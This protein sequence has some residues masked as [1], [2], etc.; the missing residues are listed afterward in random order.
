M[1]GLGFILMLPFFLLMIFIKPLRRYLQYVH[2]FWAV[3][4]LGFSG[5]PWRIIYQYRPQRKRQYVICSN[6]FSILDIVTMG[7]LPINAVFVGKSSLAKIPLFGYMFRK[8]HITVD[9]SSLKDR[10]RALQKA[11]QAVDEGKSL[12]MFPEGGV[13]TECPPQMIRFK[14]GPFRVAIEKQ[15]PILPITIPYNWLILPDDKS[16]LLY[17]RTLFVVVHPA[18]ET[19]GLGMDAIP[20]L[21]QQLYSTIDEELKKYNPDESRQRDPAKDCAPGTS[22]V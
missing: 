12:I 16:Y 3:F 1:F 21:Q 15:I 13:H 5:V 2:W 17:P 4:F 7:F 9:R 14:E 6:H 18:I 20:R 19:K 10:Y 11:M 22:R 8:L